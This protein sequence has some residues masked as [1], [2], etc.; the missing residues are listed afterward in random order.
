M[1]TA[2]VEVQLDMRTEVP[3]AAL[4]TDAAAQCAAIIRATI[5]QVALAGAYEVS[6]VITGDAQMRRINQRF[7]GIDKTTDVLSFPQSDT[8]LLALPPQ[9]RWVERPFGDDAH[10]QPFIDASPLNARPESPA[11]GAPA[12]GE[13][14]HLG[15][16][17]IAAPTVDRQAAQ[18]GHSAWWECGF[19]LAH[20]TLH[21][22][23]YDDYYEP[24]Y[25]AMVAHQEA[26]LAAL[27]M[28][29]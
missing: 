26:V 6:L 12:S 25:R 13:P 3:W 20:G 2:A 23:G 15:D 7:R 18:A 16:I 5:A 21:L 24:G 11:Y 4:P 28:R 9:E 1:G 8:P 27:D 17:I 19:L 10:G 22:L 29:R 14:F